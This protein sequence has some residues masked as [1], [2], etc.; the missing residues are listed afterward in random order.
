MI[1]RIAEE[2]AGEGRV[3]HGGGLGE[4]GDPSQVQRVDSG[5][6]DLV[7]YAVGTDTIE[8]DAVHSELPFENERRA[9]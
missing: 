2:L 6:E 8:T 9:R 1:R 3:L 7:T 4:V 5:G